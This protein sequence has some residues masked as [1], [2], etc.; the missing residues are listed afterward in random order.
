MTANEQPLRNLG[1]DLIRATE[2]AALA[3]GRWMGLGKPEEADEAAAAA[4]Y[5]VLNTIDI[6]AGVV[7]G[8]QGKLHQCQLV[9]PGAHA[10]TGAGPRVDIVPDA[11]DGCALLAQGYP[12]ALSVVA[13]APCGSFWAPV[14]AHYMDKMV[15]DATVGPALVP[16][17]L[18][19]P[20]A[21]TLALVA[22]TKGKNVSDLV[23]FVLDRPRHADLVAEIRAAGARTMLRE[24]GDIAG[25]LM[26]VLADGSVDILM[27]I[28][29][30]TEGLIAACAVKASGGA[31]LGRL[32]P[33]SARERSEVE[34]A[35]LDLHRILTLEELVTSDELFFVATGI[36]DGPL[37]SGVAYHGTLATSNSM[38]L[39]GQTRTRRL[40]R[41]EHRLEKA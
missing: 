29:G 6:D 11:I 41:A 7:I 17:C 12:G 3:A 26:A 22:R 4:M 34:A 14:P 2:A 24:E 5:E 32:A 21:W 38:I 20:A 19:A 35:G 25:A 31:M 10:G 23:V 16:E 18:D 39:R 9:Q 36:T 33:Q 1:F 27:G 28:G 37:L 8:E 13:A 40:I 30:V 15:V